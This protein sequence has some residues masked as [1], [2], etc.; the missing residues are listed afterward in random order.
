MTSA[1]GIVV[2]TTCITRY[3]IITYGSSLYMN[4][5][6]RWVQRIVD[7]SPTNLPHNGQAVD[8]IVNGDSRRLGYF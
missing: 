6:S 7:N 5:K 2:T 4:I 3:I 1:S 8:H